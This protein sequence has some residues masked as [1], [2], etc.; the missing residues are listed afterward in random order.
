MM[1]KVIWQRNKQHR[2]QRAQG[3]IPKCQ[4]RVIPLSR[5]LPLKLYLLGLSLCFGLYLSLY[6]NNVLGAAP[7]QKSQS[8]TPTHSVQ[9]A[10]S[11]H[12]TQ[13]TQSQALNH[14]HAEGKISFT[15]G[16]K[17]GHGTIFWQQQGQKYSIRL[18]GALGSGTL[19]IYGRP[20]YVG[21]VQS[22]GE[23]HS[24]TNAEQLIQ[25]VLGWDIPVSPLRYWLQGQPVPGSKPQDI[26]FNSA[27]Q[28]I[29]LRQQGWQI[30]Y[31][32]YTEQQGRSL[33]SRIILKHGTIQL[34]FLFPKWSVF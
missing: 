17:G 8:Q 3:R 18:I 14:F 21:M 12:T 33:P 6:S 19:E 23:T 28:L 26:Q 27:G 25:K 31:D 4:T 29:Y 11:T 7:S 16:K 10:Q 2:T 9:S 1:Q 20:G 13:T 32:K 24:A 5:K 15:N 22:N 34:K 30:H